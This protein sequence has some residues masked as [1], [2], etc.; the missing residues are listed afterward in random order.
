M[1]LTKAHECVCEYNIGRQDLKKETETLWN[2]DQQQK[3]NQVK[4]TDYKT[5]V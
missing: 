2:K 1:L 5:T 4:Y 3:C